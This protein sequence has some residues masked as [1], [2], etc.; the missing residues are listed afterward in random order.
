[1]NLRKWRYSNARLCDQQHICPVWTDQSF[2]RRSIFQWVLMCST[3]IYLESDFNQGLLKNKDRKL[4]QFII[5]SY[6][7]INDV[8]LLNNSRIDEY[9]H[10]IHP[11]KLEVLDTTSLLLI[12]SFSLQCRR[13]RN[14]LVVGFTTIYVIRGN[15]HQNCELKSRLSQVQ[16]MY[17][18]LQKQSDIIWKNRLMLSSHLLTNKRVRNE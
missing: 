7:F 11:N 14:R 16:Y 18:R 6:R 9:I 15:Y 2:N 3:M 17:V 1:M 8:L 12:S 10:L 4:A 5:S 13:G